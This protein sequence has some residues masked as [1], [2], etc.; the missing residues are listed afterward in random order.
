MTFRAPLCIYLVDGYQ[1]EA[2]VFVARY[3][4]GLQMLSRVML[5][6]ISRDMTQTV[7]DAIPG[8]SCEIFGGQSGAGTGFLQVIRFSTV[9]IIPSVLHTRFYQHVAFTRRTGGRSW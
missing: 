4:L 1:K 6:F 7:P 5:I 8:Q 9:I 2:I 3:E